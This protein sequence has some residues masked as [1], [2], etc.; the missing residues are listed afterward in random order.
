MSLD[1]VKCC[2]PKLICCRGMSTQKGGPPVSSRE[3]L[4]HVSLWSVHEI[5]IHL[6][7]KIRSL[8]AFWGE[9]RRSSAQLSALGQYVVVDHI[10]MA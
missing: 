1:E 4:F 9:Y 8:K 6:L 2:I 10:N 7:Y 5:D 3:A